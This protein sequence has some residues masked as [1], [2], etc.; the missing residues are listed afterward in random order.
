MANGRKV[1]KDVGK[2]LKTCK[3]FAH[4][5][6]ALYKYMIYNYLQII[7]IYGNNTEYVSAVCVASMQILQKSFISVSVSGVAFR[8]KSVHFAC[9]IFV[10]KFV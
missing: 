3:T 1:D 6:F 5:R 10:H 4:S 2:Q 8:C 9:K 7:I